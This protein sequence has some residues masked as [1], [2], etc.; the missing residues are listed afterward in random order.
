MLE[1]DRT[2]FELMEYTPVARANLLRGCAHLH[3]MVEGAAQVVLN[4]WRWWLGVPA[5]VGGVPRGWCL[6]NVDQGVQVG[7]GVFGPLSST[8]C[9]CMTPVTYPMR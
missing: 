8:E 4:E 1:L 5:G 7:V 9:P 3:G 6:Y 2:R